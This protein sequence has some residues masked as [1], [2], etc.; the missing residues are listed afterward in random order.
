MTT[1][2]VDARSLSTASAHR[3]IGVYL[4]ALLPRLAA[5][6]DLDVAALATTGTELPPGVRRIPMRRSAPGRF[7]HL[8]HLLRLPRDLR[9]TRH[10]VFHS[11]ATEPPRNEPGPWVQ[12]L[13]DVIP[14]EIDVP[15]FRRERRRWRQRARSI[16]RAHAVITPSRHSADAGI[17]LLGLEAARVHVVP[18]GVGPAFRPA[19][20]GTAGPPT[21]LYVGEYGP[22]KGYAEAFEVVARLADRGLPHRLVVVGRIAPWVAPVIEAEVRRSARPDRIHLAGYVTEAELVGL[23]Q[24]ADALVVTSRAEGFGLPVVE[25]MACGTPVI[26]FA[27][28]SLT[29]VVDG[30]GE[31][32]ADGDVVEFASRLASLLRDGRRRHELSQAGLRRAEDFDWD[33]CA[34]THAEILRSVATS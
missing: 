30:A 11:P 7:E 8:E 4:G 31:L 19:A 33:A 17:R 3:G 15:E 24:Q 34:T 16:G 25:A 29:E 5:E 27:N 18:L 13:L 22:H 26:A 28:S 10:D 12:T 6:A 2:L 1:V 20:T 32:V 21:V 9:R 23:Y 14:L